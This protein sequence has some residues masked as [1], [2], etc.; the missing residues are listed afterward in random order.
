MGPSLGNLGGDEDEGE[1][2]RRAEEEEEEGR[3]GKRNDGTASWRREGEG[4]SPYPPVL[5][6]AVR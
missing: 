5:G 2:R 3:G 4:G 1:E 6:P